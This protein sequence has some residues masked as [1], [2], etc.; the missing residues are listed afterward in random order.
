[1]TS[2]IFIFAFLPLAASPQASVAKPVIVV[3]L[4]DERP[5]LDGRLGDEFWRRA[6]DMGLFPRADGRGMPQAPTRARVARTRDALWLGVVC[7]E[8]LM[9]RLRASRIERDSDVWADDC[10]EVFL[11]QPGRPY[12]HFAVNARGAQFDE[13]V[14]DSRWNAEWDAA[15]RREA[16]R[17]TVELRLPWRAL[18]RMPNQDD[19]WRLN[20]CRSRRTEYELSAWSPTG[21][22][23]HQPERFGYV[24]FAS[25]PWPTRVEW[26]LHT[27][28]AGRVDLAWR[29]KAA[30]VALR[31]NGVRSDGEFRLEREGRVP[32]V[33]EATSMGRAV[34]RT[35]YIANIAP[36][37]EAFARAAKQL[38]ALDTNAKSIASARLR[39]EQQLRSL[40]QLAAQAAPALDKEL[41]RQAERIEAQASHLAVKAALERAGAPR[42][43]IVYGVESSLRKLL[44]HRPFQGQ[45]GGALR[46]DAA[47]GEMD[48]QQLVVFAFDA[49]LLHV[50]V[51]I[52]DAKSSK[53]DALPASA[54]RVRRVGYIPTVKPVYHVE[55]V[56]L[57]PD[58]LM[59]ATAFDVQPG[60]FESLWIDVRVPQGAKPGLYRGQLVLSAMNARPTVVPMEVRVRNFTIPTRPSLRTA[61]GLSPHWRVKQDFD[62]YVRNALEHRV[63]PYSVG[64]PKLLSPPAMDWRNVLRM[65]V[66]V[67]ADR[68]G[69]LSLVVITAKGKVHS[70][71]AEYV[72]PGKV[73]HVAFELARCRGLIRSWRLNLPGPTR[74]T[75]TVRL[76]HE[77]RKPEIVARGERFA[78]LG[79]DGWLKEWPSWEGSAWDR[80]DVPAQWDWSQFDENVAK[81]LPLGLTG[82]RAAIG[83]PRT[84]WAREW[85]RHLRKKGWLHL[86]YTYLFDE[87]RPEDYPKLNRVMGEVKRAAPG[88]MNMM[89]A[90]H[91]PRELLY[92]DIWCPEAFSFDPEAA[93]REQKRGRAVWWYVAFSTRHPYP[94][95]WIDYP[96]LDCRVW[97]WMTWKHDLDG[98]LYWSVTAWGR[99][100][101]WLSGQTFP[102][103]NGD[104]SMLYPGPDGKPVDSIRWE[105]LRD[106]LEDYEVFCLLE[107]GVRD[108]EARKLRPD[109]AKRAR[110]LIAIPDDVV[111][112]YK[113][114]NPDPNALLNTRREMS[115]VLEE[116]VAALGYEPK[117][118]GRPR[119]RPGVDLSKIP[120]E[121]AAPRSARVP[122]WTPPALAR[123]PGLVLRYSF[124]AAAPFAFDRSGLGMHGIVEGAKRVR[125]VAGGALRF[126]RKSV[127]IL[128]PAA[129]LLGSQPKNGTVA[130]WVRPRFDPSSVP[131]GLWEG[132]YVIFYLM[133]TDGNGLPDGYDEIGL[134]VHGPRL[135]ARC[136]GHEGAFCGIPTPLRQGEW[137]HVCLT[138]TTTERRL[139]V[140]GKLAARV[141]RAFPLPKLDDFHGCLGNHPPSRRWPWIGDVDEFRIYR[142]CLTPD[143]VTRLAKP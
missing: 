31:V 136:A 132:Y 48:A 43:A 137:T 25:G 116:I 58:P 14:K 41:V 38:R 104:G 72:E 108:L 115:E 117:I 105:C 114:Y 40:R 22:G 4:L 99:A 134:Y 60:G 127:V 37:S 112:S 74:A 71:T 88:L 75:A 52:S 6:A 8:P 131:S 107:A 123:E 7:M 47:R 100:D 70:L 49:P 102:G 109:L 87:P 17:W 9:N 61:F 64:S 96:A 140:N 44:R 50:T 15:V 59:P 111:E 26:R 135:W 28:R 139:Y 82:V 77:G 133:Q 30:K 142:R 63:S 73:Q 86:A 68:Q 56:G 5:K 34:F 106:G 113:H 81:Y 118:V 92:V 79:K 29:P 42:D 90:R 1:M 85:E 89:T 35:V 39:L 10:I 94:N 57:W 11:Q 46:L 24:C 84:A 128:P 125:G 101:P 98:M 95:V 16:D 103:A 76:I 51:T 126:S 129:V 67:T 33:L 93:A 69:R 143:E 83:N 54:F 65:E 3:P 124:D 62:A 120:D 36:V 21:G 122:A 12:L 27:R 53:G 45:A 13:R 91:F 20:V 110:A 2:A 18:G 32:L 55:H 121:E 141:A 19:T 130:A 119:H 78:V 66:E 97:P 23:F 80:P 138:W